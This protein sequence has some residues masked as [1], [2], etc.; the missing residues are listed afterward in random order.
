MFFRNVFIV[1]AVKNAVLHGE[2]VKTPHNKRSPHNRLPTENKHN[3]TTAQQKK[4]GSHAGPMQ[5]QKA[6][7]GPMQSPASLS[8]LRGN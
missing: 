4:T 3:S 8:H 7:A 5:L 2:P 6:H 1:I